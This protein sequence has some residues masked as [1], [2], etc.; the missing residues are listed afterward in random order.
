MNALS[1]KLRTLAN[2]SATLCPFPGLRHR[3]FRYAGVEIGDDSYINMSVTMIIEPEAE[4][5]VRIGRRNAIAPGVVFAASS[6]A[7]KSLVGRFYPG[8]NKTI[9]LEDDVWVGANATILPGV[10]IGRMAVVAAGAVVADDVE[11]GAVVGG[12]PAKLLKRLPIDAAESESD[13]SSAD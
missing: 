4:A 10:R 13:G 2:R 6:N 9:V 12:T 5:V 7:N 3:L 1:R 8:E 11:P